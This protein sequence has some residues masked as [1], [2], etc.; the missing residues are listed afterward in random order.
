MRKPVVGISGSY[1]QSEDM[2]VLR[3][4]YIS[5]II[6]SDCVPLILPSTLSR[7]DVGDVLSKLDGLVLS[8]GVDI[9]PSFYGEQPNSHLGEVDGVRDSFEINL[10][11]QAKEKKLPVFGICRG[12]QTICVAMGGSLWQDLPS[13][14]PFAARHHHIEGQSPVRHAVTITAGTRLYQILH[15]QSIETNSFHH[16]AV[17]S[18]PESFVVSACAEDGIIEAI[19]W[20]GNAQDWFCLGVQWHPERMYEEYESAREIFGAFAEACKNTVSDRKQEDHHE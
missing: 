20:N 14:K 12:V 10:M 13:Q 4:N 18:C 2:I 5:C 17:K 3:N 6:A 1:E 19:E 11:L 7:A 16:Q 9:N 15:E 8:G